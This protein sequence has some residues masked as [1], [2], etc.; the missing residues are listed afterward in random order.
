L[1][2]GEQA[3]VPSRKFFVIVR[4]DRTIQRSLK[5]WIPRTSRGMTPAD[6]LQST[7]VTGRQEGVA[8]LAVKGLSYAP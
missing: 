7:S 2:V 5:N 8:G 1:E 4:R 6:F 3:G